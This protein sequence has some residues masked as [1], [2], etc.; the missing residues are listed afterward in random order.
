LSNQFQ[1]HAFTPIS[2][3]S[4]NL[5]NVRRT[6][7]AIPLENHPALFSGFIR[8]FALIWAEETLRLVHARVTSF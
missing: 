1:A 7:A 5:P 6:K 8:D 2:L 4:A 3:K